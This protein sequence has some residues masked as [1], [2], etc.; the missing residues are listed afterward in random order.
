MKPLLYATAFVFCF[1]NTVTAQN[2]DTTLSRYAKNYS[3][4]KMYLQ[5]DKSSYASGETVWFKDYLMK[6]MLPRK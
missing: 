4:E 6:G 3:P 2:I 5:Y 1:L